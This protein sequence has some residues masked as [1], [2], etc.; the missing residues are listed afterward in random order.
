MDLD[1]IWMILKL[2]VLPA[3]IAGTVF[4]LARQLRR[5]S[6]RI[7]TRM[8][9]SVAVVFSATILLLLSLGEVAC[10]KY[11]RPSYSPDGKHVATISYVLQGA[12]GDDYAIVL[13]RSSWYPF[14]D[15]VYVGLG[16]WDSKREKP[17]SPELQW[18]DDSRLLIRYS[19]DR[20]GTEGRGGPATCRNQ[21]GN[22][23]ILCENLSR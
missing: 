16:N 12:L 21:V 1:Q 5:R 13:V 15:R 20:T 10:T 18:L 19:D 7:A 17:D 14:A 22:I 4:R 9:A 3:L 11:A 2:I 23:R 6:M 8:A